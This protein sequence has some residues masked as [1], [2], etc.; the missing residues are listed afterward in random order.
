[1]VLHRNALVATLKGLLEALGLK[2]R[3]KP[4]TTTLEDIVRE[5]DEK[6]KALLLLER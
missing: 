3:A 5:Y 6:S 2:R 1:M 4:L